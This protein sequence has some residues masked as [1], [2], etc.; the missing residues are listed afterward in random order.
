MPTQFNGFGKC[1][2]AH[3]VIEF[4]KRFFLKQAYAAGYNRQ[5]EDPL[6]AAAL[7]AHLPVATERWE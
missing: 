6:E 4:V 5:P 3:Q 2:I 1:A 7:V